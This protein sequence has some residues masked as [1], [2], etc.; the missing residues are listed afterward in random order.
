V[1]YHKGEN[2]KAGATTNFY[3]IWIFF[4]W[5]LYLGNMVHW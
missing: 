4:H 3:K 5:S 2:W 1:I